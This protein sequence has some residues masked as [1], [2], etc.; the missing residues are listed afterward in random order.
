[1]VML[2][3]KLKLTTCIQSLIAQHVKYVNRNAL[4]MFKALNTDFKTHAVNSYAR[5]TGK[6]DLSSYEFGSIQ[7]SD[8]V[9][10]D[11]CSDVIMTN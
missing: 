2:H 7:I 11:R 10:S 8:S 9:I 6:V 3:I 1:M 5:E 4:S